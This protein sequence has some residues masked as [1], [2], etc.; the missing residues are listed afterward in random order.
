MQ[1]LFLYLC[2]SVLLLLQPLLLLQSASGTRAHIG[3]Q[4]CHGLQSTQRS[5][6]PVWSVGVRV[7]RPCARRASEDIERCVSAKLVADV[8]NFT[9]LVN[10]ATNAATAVVERGDCGGGPVNRRR[11]GY[12]R[13]GMWYKDWPLMS[14]L[15]LALLPLLPRKCA[16]EY[17]W[18]AGGGHCRCKRCSRR[19]GCGSWATGWL[20]W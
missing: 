7:R 12:V 14:P 6:P 16:H 5:R 18:A 4:S 17:F 10:S 13:V 1:L 11:R 19:S 3:K 9:T 20:L 15:A 8:I 2:L